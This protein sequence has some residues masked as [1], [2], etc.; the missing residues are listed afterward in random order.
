M[1]TLQL[2]T[3]LIT[4][5][6]L[7]VA[8]T[9]N[10]AAAVAADLAD[11]PVPTSSPAKTAAT[12]HDIPIDISDS[13]NEEHLVALKNYGIAG[14]AHYSRKDGL[15]A[16]YYRCICD[17]KMS[18]YLRKGT[19]Q[20]LRSV[21]KNL[22]SLGLE[23]LVLDA[24]RPVKCQEALWKDSLAEAK[25]HLGDKATEEELV[26]R[27]SNF[28]SNPTKYDP[29]NWKTW[30]THL[31]GGAVDLTLRRKETGE[32]MYMGGIYDDG[33]ALSETSYYEAKEHSPD[34]SEASA[35]S[36][37]ARRNRR[38]LYWAM[39]KEGFVNYPHEWWHF[40]FGNQMAVQNNRSGNAIKAFYGRI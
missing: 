30:P 8:L 7:L 13:K 36:I 32:L 31:T 35:S 37:E 11:Q 19:A 2:T 1:P 6:S 33:S 3:Q 27:A 12:Y 22:A 10:F 14:D 20:R 38:I 9:C 24:Y 21:N 18:L 26:E 40:D 25:R 15:N 5:L 34:S 17:G 4:R 23:V 39:V 29:A 28:C 16:P